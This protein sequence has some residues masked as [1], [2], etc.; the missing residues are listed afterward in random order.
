MSLN[1]ATPPVVR[2]IPERWSE[3]VPIS[4]T[5]DSSLLGDDTLTVGVFLARFSIKDEDVYFH[6]M[7]FK[8]RTKEYWGKSIHCPRRRGTGVSRKLT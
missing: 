5:W 4:I 8:R 7:H 6:S 1:R 2:L 3:N